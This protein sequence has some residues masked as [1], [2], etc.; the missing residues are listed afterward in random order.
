MSAE[1]KS[2]RDPDNLLMIQRPWAVRGEEILKN[3]GVNPQEGLS[4]EEKE[5]RKRR[6]GP[7]ELKKAEKKSTLSVFI[8]QFKSVL[9]ILLTVAVAASFLFNQVIEG[10][11]ILAV[12]VINTIIG[13]VTEMR[14]IRSMEALYKMTKV[15]A[16]VLR[17]GEVKEVSADDLVPGDIVLLNAGDVI[18][19]DMRLVEASNL[20][21]DES[22][23]T[24][25][26]IPVSKGIKTVGRAAPM[27]ERT[28]MT[29]KGTAVTKGS[30]KGVVV[31]TGLDTEL[32][33]IS[34]L[35][36]EAE[37][38]ATP[39]EKRLE[40]LGQK[41]IYIM[42]IIAGIVAI[43]GIVRGKDLYLMIETSIAL[44]VATV[45]EGLPI[46]ATV[47]LARGMMRMAKRNALVNKLSAVETLGSTNVICTDKT[48]TL[49]ENK[50]TVTKLK[51]EE[52]DYHVTGTGME[53]E[54]EFRS[55]GDSFDPLEV[56][57][58]EEMLRI[59]VFC[60]NAALKEDDDFV[61]DPMEVALL[62]AGEKAGIK[63]KELVDKYPEE[64]EVSFD[65]STKM[66]ATFHK[67]ND[68][69]LVAVKGAPEAVIGCCE[70]VIGP[71][72][73]MEFDDQKKEKWLR[74]NSELAQD[75]LRILAFAEKKVGNVDEEPYAN[76]TFLGLVGLMDPPRKEV[77][78]AIEKC[79]IAGIR[80]IMVTGDQ[81]ATARNVGYTVGLVE[82]IGADVVD[83]RELKEW[84]ELDEEERERM[85]KSSIFARVSPEEKLFLIDLHQHNDSVVAMTGDGVNDAP[86]LKK[87]DIG[88]SMGQRGTQVAKEASDMILQDDNFATI[89]NA[90]EQGRIIFNNIRSFVYY[91]LSCNLSELLVILLATSI[92]IPLPILPLQILFLNVVTDIFPAFALGANKGDE[93]IMEKEP[94]RPSEPVLTREHWQ[95]IAS[96]G[97]MITFSV[98]GAFLLASLRFGMFIDGE[99]NYQVVTVS[100]LTLAFA[101]LW[102]VF[103]MRERGSSF[104]HNPVV[105]NK[106][107]WGALLLCVGLLLIATYLPGLSMVLKTVDPGIDGWLIITVFSLLPLIIGQIWNS[108]PKE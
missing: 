41:L 50:M 102:H 17:E 56:K 26:S 10:I 28:G 38:E 87:A 99:V 66:M 42:L 100:F 36:E 65:P 23:L 52:G 19:A 22:A 51:S 16:R 11:A 77:K 71:R 32:G 30:G 73:E 55:D 79:K 91:L 94:R 96:Y 59:G 4:I 1:P 86:A 108:I 63:R 43:S 61:G 90:V 15:K 84:G 47:A 64:R 14:A 3:I 40:K 37:E 57:R 12:I 78:S 83:G 46:V 101:Q 95:G 82:G 98:L 67:V 21:V 62:V 81:A 44:A 34:T 48:G 54:G 106:Y 7:N 69:F 2:K 5:K 75:G 70:R 74:K 107:V 39:L 85:V 20:N 80:V 105:R 97:L 88:V 13:F 18:T 53:R 93:G 9:V 72:G 8:E 24:G 31:T 68:G 49:T 25:E 92:D 60:N 27:A 76:L 104:F 58:L 103:N 33:K 45:P 6:Y 29:Y 35:V 89:T